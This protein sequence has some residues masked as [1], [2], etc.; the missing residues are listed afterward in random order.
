[1]EDIV[2]RIRVL[3]ADD[4]GLVRAGIRCL[5]KKLPGVEVVSSAQRTG[6]LSTR[7]L[8]VLKRIAES[9]TTKEIAEVLK[10]S[11]KTVETHRAELMKRLGIHDVA[12]LVRY[13]I[14]QGLLPPAGSSL[15]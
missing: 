7:Q 5:L 14:Q 4:H 1:V 15:S 6:G 3:L 13:A 12:G 8:E 10:I 11:P 9:K 2:K